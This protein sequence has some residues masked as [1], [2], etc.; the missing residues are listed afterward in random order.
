M[1]TTDTTRTDDAAE[2]ENFDE[3]GFLTAEA[4]RDKAR[5]TFEESAL[6]IPELGG[7]VGLRAL[8]V[9]QRKRLTAQ[10]PDSVKNW[11]L[12]HTAMGLAAYVQH[13]QMTIKEWTE[14]IAPWPALALDRLQNEIRSLSDI[15]EKEEAAAAMEFPASGD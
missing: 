2:A 8:S 6:E 11:K 15:D 12:E 1:E 7:K 14:T 5:F 3:N 13:P 9:G 4:L 10:Y